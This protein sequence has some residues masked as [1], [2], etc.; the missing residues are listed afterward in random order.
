M[1]TYGATLTR[2]KTSASPVNLNGDTNTTAL[3]PIIKQMQFTLPIDY[4][5]VTVGQYS[6][7]MMARTDV[8]RVMAATGLSRKQAGAINIDSIG[9]IIQKFQEV[10]DQ[11]R[12]VLQRKIKLR[13]VEYGFIPSL[14]DIA[15][16]EYTDATGLSKLVFTDNKWSELSKLL[17]IFYRPITETFGERY[18]IEPY[19]S[20][21][22]QGRAYVMEDLTMD[23]ASGVSL[24]FSL[25][26]NEYAIDSHRCSNQ[27]MTML[28]K[29]MRETLKIID[30]E[31]TQPLP[32][33]GD[34]TIS[35]R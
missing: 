19:D 32:V 26:L 12:G 15:F 31:M 14:D 25:I 7:F 30:D 22:L 11:G 9:K 33:N 8:E 16:D 4:S 21:K 20:D 18:A 28:A 6:T 23:I 13:G 34:G 29:E 24:F 27:M 2:A 10:L 17:A 5:A 3:I 1:K 35:S